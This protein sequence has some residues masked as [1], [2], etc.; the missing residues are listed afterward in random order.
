MTLSKSSLKTEQLLAIDRLSTRRSTI[1]IAPTGAGKTVTC[2][3][4]IKQIK[5]QNKLER[6]IVACPPKVISVWPSE[7]KKWD[8]LKGLKVSTLLGDISQREAKLVTPSDI[9]VVSLNNLEWLLRQDHGCDGIIVDEL[10]KAAGKQTKGLKTKVRGD[11]FK[12]RVGMTATPVSQDF[13]KLFSMCRIIDKGK[14]L[15]TN[16]HT[17]LNRYFYS[18]YMG[19]NWTLKDGA[20]KK[21]MSKI[22][23]LVHIVDDTKAI[24]LPNIKRNEIRFE[25]PDESRTVYNKMKRDMIADDYDADAANEAVKSGKLRQIASG[26]IYTD[27]VNQKKA[28]YI[29]DARIDAAVDWWFDTADKRPAVIFYEFVA[30]GEKLNKVFHKYLSA[31]VEDFKEGSG[32]LLIAQINSLSHGVDGLQNVSHDALF[33]HPMWSR[34]AMEQAEGRLWRTGATK[35][36]NIYTLV[37]DNTLDDLVV[38]RVEDRGVWMKIFKKHL[39]AK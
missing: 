38:N 26:F 7:V 13:E 14:R 2:L 8:H 16:V 20:D 5:S 23:T 27:D 35:P 33:Y 12:W 32:T 9:L 30:Q 25:M 22:S 19:W 37:C 15:G 39:G 36:V 31:S 21:I 10:S 4:A 28:N 17:Y 29:D 6:I 3:S 11:C 24:D 1:L 18:D 34:D